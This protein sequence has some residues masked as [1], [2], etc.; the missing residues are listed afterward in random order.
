MPP[1]ARTSATAAKRPA[2]HPTMARV[3][4]DC[5]S[6]CSIVATPNIGSW[7]SI[8]A[9]TARAGSTSDSAATAVWRT[10]DIVRRGAWAR[11]T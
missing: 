3:R 2:S 8:S 1:T 6:S 9:N 4:S 5:S 11:G 7:G 10:I